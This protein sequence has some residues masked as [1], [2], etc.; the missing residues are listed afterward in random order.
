MTPANWAIRPQVKI[1]IPQPIR[2]VELRANSKCS[3]RCQRKD[4]LLT[5][6]RNGQKT[7]SEEKLHVISEVIEMEAMR[8]NGGANRRNLSGAVVDEAESQR[9]R[10]G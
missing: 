10:P 3:C 4:V 8:P 6:Q 9:L 2:L 1:Q 7:K 5:C